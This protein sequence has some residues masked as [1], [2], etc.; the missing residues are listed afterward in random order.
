LPKKSSLF[1]ADPPIPATKPRGPRNEDAIQTGEDYTTMAGT[2][3][4]KKKI[5]CL[6]GLW[7]NNLEQRL[8]VKPILEIISKLNG[9][10]FTHCPC[11]TKSEFLFHLYNFTASK[12]ISKY[13]ILYLAFHGHSGRIVLSDQ[14]Q[15]NLKE[16]ADLMGQQF[17]GW[18]VLL[19]CCSILS[20]GE[21]RIESFI[22]QTQVSLVIGYRKAVDW[23]ESISLDLIILDH[24]VNYSYLAW[25]RKRIETRYP[26]LVT[27]TGLRF[28]EGCRRRRRKRK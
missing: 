5:L 9:I 25:M 8:S 10:R 2:T 7:D 15:L 20:L 23:G 24:L 21:K 19:S 13:S 11:N 3:P 6:E 17:R 4:S 12:I 28:Y 1:L 14:E 26:D 22:N 18:S 27:A 16:L